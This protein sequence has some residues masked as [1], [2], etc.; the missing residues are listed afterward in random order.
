MQPQKM[1]LLKGGH[2]AVANIV[3]GLPVP[4]ARA[5]SLLESYGYRGNGEVHLLLWYVLTDISSYQ[6]S[7][8][9]WNVLLSRGPMRLVRWH[10][11]CGHWAFFSR[12]RLVSIHRDF[13][14]RLLKP[15]EE[16][17]CRQLVSFPPHLRPSTLY[18]HS[19]VKA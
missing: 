13:L 8:L 10:S 4:A 6:R 16:A 19:I 9:K 5:M 17:E 12:V 2:G 18:R 14:E 3:Y 15:H 7:Q 1:F 11:L